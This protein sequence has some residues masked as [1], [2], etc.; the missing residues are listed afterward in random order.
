[1]SDEKTPDTKEWQIDSL[2]E[3]DDIIELTDE[4]EP[5]HPLKAPK[6]DQLD[7][8][9]VGLDDTTLPPEGEEIQELT[10]AAI[11][12]VDFDELTPLDETDDD[13]IGPGTIPAMD[14]EIHDPI[15]GAADG[16]EFEDLETLQAD[17]S[18]IFDLLEDGR[19]TPAEEITDLTGE[20]LEDF[21][22]DDVPPVEENMEDI[23]TLEDDSEEPRLEGLL[24]EDDG[25]DISITDTETEVDID[26]IADLEPIVP[27]T[28]PEVEPPLE[29]ETDMALHEKLTTDLADPVPPPGDDIIEISEFDQQYFDDAPPAG[30]AGVL[31]TT[32]EA[33]EDDFLELIDVDEADDESADLDDEIIHFD[34]NTVESSGSELDDILSDPDHT[35]PE[36]EPPSDLDADP[37]SDISSRLMAETAAPV[38]ASGVKDST[39]ADTSP[40][41]F[42][43]SPGEEAGSRMEAEGASAI[44]DEEDTGAEAI[45]AA[46]SSAQIEAAVANIIERDYAGQI[47]NIVATAIEKVVRLEIERI[48]TKLFEDDPE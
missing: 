48:K 3:E 38:L 13:M 1:M 11:D 36:L 45:P 35:E 26:E 10:E 43:S 37:Y 31:P 17:E 40:A 41:F 12:E 24:P 25:E 18:R 4:I 9:V 42:E 15:G 6:Q 14:E 28:I 8:I 33:E 21:D 46:I 29:N 32:D 7:E 23:I 39:E 2:E 16:V 5:P 47:E 19:D 30:E 22:D 20:V 44:E 34:Q 27:E